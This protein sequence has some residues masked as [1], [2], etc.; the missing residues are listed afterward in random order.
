[1]DFC[2]AGASTL[3][4]LAAA[5]RASILV[6]F[7]GAAD[8]HQLR[9]AEAL[10]S[11]GGAALLEQHHLTPG[12]LASEITSLLAAPGRRMAMQSAAGAFARPDAAERIAE[13]VQA[14]LRA[15]K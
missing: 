5:R 15:T 12:R 14:Q 11:A 8:Q 13:L 1:V 10:A 6:P 4:E 7:P 9:N 2:R 3:G